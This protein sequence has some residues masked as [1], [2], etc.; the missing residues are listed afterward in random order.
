MDRKSAIFQF[1]DVLVDAGNARIRTRGQ[2]VA[3]EP[4]AFRL[5]V[6]LLENRE[7]LIEKEELLKAIWQE[8]FVSE[9]VLTWGIDLLRKALRDS[10]TDAPI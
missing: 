8:I 2:R 10:A 7:R 5:L 9:N 3:V 6:Y 4:K 1:D